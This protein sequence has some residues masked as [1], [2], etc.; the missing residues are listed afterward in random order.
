M[1]FQRITTSSIINVIAQAIFEGAKP[2]MRDY[3]E[4]QFLVHSQKNPEGFIQKGK[5]F[6]LKP[7]TEILGEKYGK[8]AIG[9]PDE[10]TDAPDAFLVTPL[11]AEQ[12]FRQ[13]L[14]HFGLSIAVRKRNQIVAGAVYDPLKDE[15]FWTEKDKG[16]F[17]NERR[18]RLLAPAPL[19]EMGL[20][21]ESP[22][23]QSP[24]IVPH[25]KLM[26]KALIHARSV[27]SFGSTLLAVAYVCAGRTHGMIGYH[28][29]EGELP[30]A[31]LLLTEAGGVFMPHPEGEN[32][33]FLGGNQ[34]AVE[35]MKRLLGT[36]V[37]AEG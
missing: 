28:F 23:T 9:T 5:S 18:L 16:S 20:F 8:F 13:G 19:K 31:Q 24:H 12:N 2:L 34:D 15:L 25:V 33:F 7:I 32:V 22:Q 27:R 4:M 14:P 21:I 11:V 29:L 37:V 36:S 35:Q 30:I 6:V 10:P 17:I 1:T 3:G 26:G